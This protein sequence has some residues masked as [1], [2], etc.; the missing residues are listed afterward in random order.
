[1][2]SRIL[3]SG[4]GGGGYAWGAGGFGGC[5]Q[6]GNGMGENYTSLAA[7][8]T[9]GFLKGRGENGRDAI[10]T[11]NGGG[12]GGAGAGGGYFGGTV[13]HAMG[14]FSNTGGSGG[15]SYISGHEGCKIHQ[16]LKFY[17]TKVLSGNELFALPDSRMN[18]G[19]NGNG[20]FR[21][22][23]IDD[24]T[25]KDIVYFRM[26]LYLLIFNSINIS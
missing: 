7:N 10:I 20:Y 14:N 24:C 21:I 26:N 11:G 2:D 19:N 4:A 25:I 5:L 13:S 1:M 23:I 12:E 16:K 3:V 15:S 18:R 9:Y 17:S 8:Q 6:A 22:K